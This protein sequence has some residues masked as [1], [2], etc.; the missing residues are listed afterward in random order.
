[1]ALSPSAKQAPA[2]AHMRNRSGF[3]ASI[4]PIKL[5]VGKG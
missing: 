4:L 5:A 1:M 3:T 2:K